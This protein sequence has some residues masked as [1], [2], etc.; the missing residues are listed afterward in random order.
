MAIPFIFQTLGSFVILGLYR[1]FVSTPMNEA[2]YKLEIVNLNILLK[3]LDYYE[4]EKGRSKSTENIREFADD[5][6]SGYRGA[7]EVGIGGDGN[8]NSIKKAEKNFNNAANSFKKLPEY[9]KYLDKAY[10]N[11]EIK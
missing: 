9:Q 8:F 10:A 3:A 11:L 7:S 6:L 2:L 1:R 4:S 5:A